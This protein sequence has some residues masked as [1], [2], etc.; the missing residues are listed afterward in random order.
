MGKRRRRGPGWT[1][2]M[3]GKRYT[4][5]MSPLSQMALVGHDSVLEVQTFA[6]SSDNRQCE[7][8]CLSLRCCEESARWS[9]RSDKEKRWIEP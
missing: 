1:C 4:E 3:A 9:C 2:S 7:G 8:D 6:K 5:V